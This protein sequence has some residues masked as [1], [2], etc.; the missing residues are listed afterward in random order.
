MPPKLWL[1]AHLDSKSQ[2]I[3]MLL[4]VVSVVTL[5]I[6]WLALLVF[7]VLAALSISI[8]LSS[9][10]ITVTVLASIAL[11]AA[12]PLIVCT[13]GNNSPGALD[14][15]SGVA[16]VLAAAEQIVRNDP[17]ASFGVLLTS[18]EELGLAGARAWT[19]AWASVTCMPTRTSHLSR[20][21]AL[22]CDSVDDT[23]S[24]IVMCP[25]RGKQHIRDLVQAVGHA[26][27]SIR[28]RGLIPGILVDAVAFTQ[29]GWC[30]MT[31]SRGRWWSL[32]RIHGRRDH[33]DRMTGVGIQETARVITN[34]AGVIIAQERASGSSAIS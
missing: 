9:L 13:V 11:L 6:V 21:I 3:P 27:A 26:A 24:T 32:A 8:S 7:T 2:P 15:A 1:V 17:D 4:R 16:T 34:I 18:A 22:N 5:A 20:P 33:V 10:S 28:I 23:G 29:A 19:H 25:G 14:N 12:I 31:I 30:A